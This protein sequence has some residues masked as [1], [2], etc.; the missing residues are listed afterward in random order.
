MQSVWVV[1]NASQITKIPLEES[2]G[3]FEYGGDVYGTESH[4]PSY[5]EYFV[6][7]GTRCAAAAAAAPKKSQ[8]SN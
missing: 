6:N 7:N 2:Q 4:D 3:Y 1:G 8:P 5:Y